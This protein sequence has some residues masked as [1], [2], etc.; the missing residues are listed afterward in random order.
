MSS[1]TIT[2]LAI[3]G[4]LVAAIA[5]LAVYNNSA[6]AIEAS[7]A[8]VAAANAAASETR[9]RTL[10]DAL[11]SLGGR[12]LAEGAKIATRGAVA[13]ADGLARKSQVAV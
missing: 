13:Y 10:G 11:V 1:G 4:V 12:A 7:N 5:G 2:A 8:N 9:G 6:R 3:G